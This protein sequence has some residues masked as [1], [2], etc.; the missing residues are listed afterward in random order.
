MTRRAGRVMALMA[1]GLLAAAGQGRA[2]EMAQDVPP[3]AGRVERRIELTVL[4]GVF[5]GGALGDRDAQALGNQAPTSEPTTLFSTS[6]RVDAAPAIEPCLSSASTAPM[7][8]VGQSAKASEAEFHIS[9]VATES[10]VGSPCPPN[11]SGP[12]RLFQPPS[13][14]RR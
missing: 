11:S 4:G 5:G 10:M 1:L 3:A 12:V 9:S 2:Q 6:A 14:Q 8:S 13:V 7:V